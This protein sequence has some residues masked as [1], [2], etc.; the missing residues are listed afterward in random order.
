[1]KEEFAKLKTGDMNP[2]EHIV[3]ILRFIEKNHKGIFECLI[4]ELRYC[5]KMVSTGQLNDVESLNK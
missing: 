5:V 2:D 3:S 4:T 1:M